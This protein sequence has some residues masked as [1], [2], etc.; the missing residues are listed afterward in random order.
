MQKII[1][2]DIGSYSIKAVEIVNT[3]KSYEIS[4]FY[5]NVIPH[6]D[7]LSPDVVIPACMEQLFRENEIEA[8]RIVTAMPGQYISSRI[9][10]FNFSDPRKISA[11]ILSEVEDVV[12]FNLDDMIIDHQVLGSM[13]EQTI[14]LVVMTR[15]NFLA[16]FLDHLQRIN[17]DPKLV[18]V[19]SLAFYNL[20]P[21][22]PM[23]PD[24]CYGIVD[25]GHEKTSVCIVQDGVLRMFRSINLGGRYLTEFLARD[26]ETDFNNAQRIKHEVSQIFCDEDNGADLQADDRMVA[27]RITLASNAIVKELG[28]TFYAFKT[29]EKAPISGVFLSGGT[30]SIKNF[31]KYLSNHLEVQVVGNRLEDSEL[32]MN[33]NLSSKMNC[34]AQGIS[35]GIRAISSVK[36]HSQI[37]LRKDE[38][39]YI[40]DYESVLRVAAEAFKIVASAL[41]LLAI[42]YGF[43]FFSYNRHIVELQEKYKKGYAA[44]FPD[45]KKKINKSNYTLSRMRKDANSK[46]NSRTKEM[47]KAISEFVN[48]NSSSGSLIALNAISNAIPKELKLDVTR[49]EFLFNPDGTG[50][51][52]IKGETDTYDTSGAILEE[53]KKIDIFDQVQEKSS[54]YKPGTDQKVIEFVIHADFIGS[55]RLDE[56]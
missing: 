32:K 12:P 35:I 10:P 22:L 43:Q 21:Y 4:N 54:G 14:A 11:A 27:E 20:C 8:D 51:V 7:E 16:S 33:P 50:R 9:L 55:M 41:A 49:Y 45:A 46:F 29:W 42:L 53:I 48:I 3:F 15:K 5:E 26:L 19:D 39:A 30:A 34:M 6:I 36:R 31:D 38:F 23:D 28:R 2:L 13:D 37:N 47:K 52:I 44:A 56:A 1:G 17:I 40:Q 25:V 24:K 18:D